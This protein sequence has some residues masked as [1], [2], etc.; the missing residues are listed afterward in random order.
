M[1]PLE[2]KLHVPIFDSQAWQSR[3]QARYNKIIKEHHKEIGKLGGTQTAKRGSDYFR[4]IG[5]LAHKKRMEN[6]QNELA[7]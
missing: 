7:K 6:Q 3:R 1:T 2:V 5:K 4:E